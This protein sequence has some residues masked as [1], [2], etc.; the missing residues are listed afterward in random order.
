M[1]KADVI[2]FYGSASKVAEILAISR[3][4]VSQWPEEVPETSAYKLESLSRGALRVVDE[5]AV[6][7]A[8]A[9]S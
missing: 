8:G 2:K 9:G 6:Q 1:K 7:G 3:A 4:A 5:A